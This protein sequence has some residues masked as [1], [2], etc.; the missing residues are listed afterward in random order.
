MNSTSSA[1]YATFIR[2]TEFALENL[3]LRMNGD[4]LLMQCAKSLNMQRKTGT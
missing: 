4:G 2:L 3:E 1:L